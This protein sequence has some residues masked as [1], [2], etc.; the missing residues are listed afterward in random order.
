MFRF[1]IKNNFF[2]LQGA[3]CAPSVA[4]VIIPGD[5]SNAAQFCGTYLASVIGMVISGIIRRKFFTIH[6]QSYLKI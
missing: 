6:N 5:Q 3:M 4:A 2:G 1:Q